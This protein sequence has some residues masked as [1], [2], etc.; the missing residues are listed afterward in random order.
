MSTVNCVN[1]SK[2]FLALLATAL[3]TGSLSKTAQ[4]GN[5]E[6]MVSRYISSQIHRLK[7]TI[8]QKPKFMRLLARSSAQRRKI[9]KDLGVK[10][11]K[12]AGYSTLYRLRARILSI[13]PAARNR[14]KSLLTAKQLKIYDTIRLEVGRLLQNKLNA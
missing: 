6:S 9:F 13:A 11:G 2:L 14:A 4:A 3:F 1:F 8:D 12:P 10:I 7:L 5:P